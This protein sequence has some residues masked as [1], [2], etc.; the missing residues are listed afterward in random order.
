MLFVSCGDKSTKNIVRNNTEKDEKV[1]TI[2]D[3][4]N[5]EI[6]FYFIF[7]FVSAN[8][9]I[10]LDTIIDKK[11]TVGKPKSLIGYADQRFNSV[12]DV[13]T[14]LL[15]VEYQSLIG[16]QVKI[17]FANGDLETVKITSI[18]IMAECIPHFGTALSWDGEFDDVVYSD[19]EKAKEI[20][21]MGKYYLVAE[22]EDITETDSEIIFALAFDE[23]PIIYPSESEDDNSKEIIERIIESLSTTEI[24]KDYQ[25]TYLEYGFSSDEKWWYA[26]EIWNLYSFIQTKN[27][28]LY[29]A[30]YQVTEQYCTTDYFFTTFSIS[31][32]KDGLLEPV[33]LSENGYFLILA[34]DINGDG[35]LEFIVDDFFG[36]RILLYWNETEWEQKYEWTIPY[37]DCPC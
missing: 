14:E 37:L 2:D 18:K 22:F 31:K 20:W 21:D 28:E 19:E 9:Y 4:T 7:G 29:V 23:S 33:Y 3:D 34:V 8:K 35:I 16:K 27:D 11:W 25:T 30:L 15:P 26:D 32:F 24:Y 5:E 12:K 1:S 10:I 6:P 36:K 17:G 13:K